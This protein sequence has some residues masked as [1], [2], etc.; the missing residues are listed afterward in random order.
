MAQKSRKLTTAI[1]IIAI[2]AILGYY[3]YTTYL[4]APLPS[5]T[6]F[7]EGLNLLD[8]ALVE[9]SLDMY[10]SPEKEMILAISDTA[11]DSAVKKINSLKQS[12]KTNALKDF[13]NIY[14]A[15][16]EEYQ[17]RKEL[18]QGADSFDALSQK[19]KCSSLN[20]ADDVYKTQQELV[21]KYKANAALITDFSEKYPEEFEKT[22]LSQK[23]FSEEELKLFTQEL[24]SMQK[25]VAEEKQKCE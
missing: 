18:M 19:E 16:I 6:N 5:I 21:T 20:K 24:Y 1:I 2:L 3:V 22:K 13:A 14:L 15:I 12:F 9:N 23:T 10:V 8:N 25:A 4:N 7:E 11:F 17:L